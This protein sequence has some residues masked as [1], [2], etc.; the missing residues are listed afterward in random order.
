M[1]I[2]DAFEG[3]DEEELRFIGIMDARISILIDLGLIDSNF[4][5][6]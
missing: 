6:K 3:E 1:Y 2:V 4:I 5:K